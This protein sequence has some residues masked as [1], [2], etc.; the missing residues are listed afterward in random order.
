MGKYL[1]NISFQVVQQ[2]LFSI[3]VFQIKNMNVNISNDLVECLLYRPFCGKIYVDL[4]VL[5]S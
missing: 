5:H 1:G 4:Y 2:R 3:D